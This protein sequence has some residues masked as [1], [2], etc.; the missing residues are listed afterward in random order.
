[1]LWVLF[2]VCGPVRIRGRRNVPRTGG[3]LVLANHTSDADPP[4]MGYAIPRPM[5][6]MAKSELFDIPILGRLMKWYRSFPVKRGAPDRG[7]LRKAI[8]LARAGECVVVFPE[9][10]CSETGKLQRIL[11]GATLIIRQSGVP[12]ICCGLRDVNR[13]LPYGKLI[14]R[15]AFHAIRVE[16]GD[17]KQFEKDATEEQIGAWIESELRRL[18]GQ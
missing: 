5:Y 10:E 18:S 8:D 4:L 13:M 15:P 12:V 1:M 6:F 7:A 2:G 11:P 17:A 3:L 16:F 14:P 9:G